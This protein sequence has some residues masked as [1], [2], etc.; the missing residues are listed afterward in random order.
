MSSTPVADEIERS[1]PEFGLSYAFRAGMLISVRIARE[2]ERAG[3][4]TWPTA[5]DE[6]DWCDQ[7]CGTDY[8][9]KAKEHT[10]WREKERG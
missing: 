2:F 6:D 10:G 5:T 8:P 3:A 4:V 7:M 9:H 1:I